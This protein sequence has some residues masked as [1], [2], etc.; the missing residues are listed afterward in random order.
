MNA[1]AAGFRLSRSL[2]IPGGALLLAAMA[3]LRWAQPEMV[4]AA[5][6]GY[7]SLIFG[8]G[9][10][11]GWR[12][13]RTRIVFA[14]LVLALSAW[15]LTQFSEGE[16]ARLVFASVALLVPLNLAAFSFLN[17]RGT[18][19]QRWG[20]GLGLV[21]GQALVIALLGWTAPAAAGRLLEGQFLGVD[22]L[23]R[24]LL[25]PAAQV[26]F[27]LVFGLFT[28]RFFLER[29]A[30]THGFL[31]SLVAVFMGMRGGASAGAGPQATVYLSTAG[32]I[33]AVAV[34]EASFR[35][36][37]W[38]E[39]TGLP[40]RRALD[41][42]LGQL[43]ED[44][45]VAMADVDHFK[46]FNDRYGHDVG[47]QVLRMVGAK[48]ASVGGGG[49][50]FRYGGEEF[51]ILFAGKSVEDALPHLEEAREAVEASRFSLRGADRPKKKPEKLRPASGAR[52]EVAVTIS[53]GVAERSPRHRTPEQVIKAA[54][55]ALYR[56]KK[57]GRN[58][59]KA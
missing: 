36:A 27:L 39:L 12:F 51:A 31:W 3:F 24:T 32:L 30:L 54:D 19:L 53:I 48:L 10:L 40:G 11:L 42:A 56:A 49:R 16:R 37:F 22:W 50:A 38:D 41:E 33:L 8:A 35:L 13:N 23:G 4:E 2:A 5:V 9:V 21:V 14:V 59:V 46:K 55:K 15:A 1:R 58:R 44:Y 26:V 52:A 57:A 34:V 29:E 28:V 17:E 6:R 7:P 20:L 47:D 18:L 25:P 45:S 43:G